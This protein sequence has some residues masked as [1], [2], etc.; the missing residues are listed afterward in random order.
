MKLSQHVDAYLHDMDQVSKSFATNMDVLAV[1][2]DVSQNGPPKSSYQ[3]LLASRTLDGTIANALAVTSIPTCSVHLYDVRGT[4]QHSFNG[5][6]GDLDAI[7][8]DPVNRDAL[9]NR[10]RVLYAH[11]TDVPNAGSVRLISLVRPV[12]SL[13]GVKYGYVEIQDDYQELDKICNVGSTG[14]VM[15]LDARHRELYPLGA[16]PLSDTTRLRLGSAASQA[17]AFPFPGGFLYAYAWSDFSGFTVFVKER[18]G[19]VL[20]PLAYLRTAAYATIVLVTVFALAMVYVLSA[21]LVKPIRKL[22]DSVVHV[23]LENMRLDMDGGAYNDEIQLLNKAFQDMLQR[24]KAAVGKAMLANRE[25]MR[26]RF[27]ALQARIAPHFIHNVLYLISVQA[28]EKRTEDVESTCKKLSDMLRYVVQSPFKTVTVDDEIA[29]AEDYL[30]LQKQNYEDFLTY[31]VSVDSS[32]RTVTLPRLVIQPFVENSI[33]SGFKKKLPP[34]KVDVRCEASTD[35]WR[36]TI[37]D[38]G[39]GIDEEAIRNLRMKI[40]EEH[41]EDDI[42]KSPVEQGIDGMGIINTYTRLRLM[43]GEALGFE[44]TSNDEGGTTVRIS[45]PMTHAVVQ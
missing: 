28:R 41:A 7:M 38:N 37:S 19:N 24:L 25:E 20:G 9:E 1:L 10:Q 39:C 43:Y 30:S 3:E 8:Q 12:F 5:R 35:R 15:V 21:V 42:L 14:Q 6:S 13:D 11:T 31:N 16:T 36:I 26:A 45:G 34:W 22:R 29:Y 2:T 44:I 23:S 27:G 4:Y 33:H 17:G 18:E 32:V 40:A